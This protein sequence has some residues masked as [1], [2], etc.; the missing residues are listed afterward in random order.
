[1]GFTIKFLIL[2]FLTTNLFGCAYSF[3]NCNR[4]AGTN[5]YNECLAVQGN[6][7][8]QYELGVSAY[9]VG[10]TKDAVKWL[11]MASAPNAPIGYFT[12]P[13][14]GNEISGPL[15]FRNSR[16]AHPGHR[17]AQLLLARLYGAGIVVEIDAEKAKRY[18]A[19][20]ELP[21]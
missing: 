21:R 11:E 5:E 7:Q 3:T 1:M 9:N 6:Q 19:L 16:D 13:M 10:N 17:E 15:M 2:S 14:V 4:Y 20:S 8:K 18:K 12:N